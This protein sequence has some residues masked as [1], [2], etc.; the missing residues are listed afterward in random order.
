MYILIPHTLQALLELGL[1][2]VDGGL[3]VTVGEE[4]VGAVGQQ[5]RAHLHS[6]LGGGLV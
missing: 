3:V 2:H 4:G 5:Q 6:V 1:G